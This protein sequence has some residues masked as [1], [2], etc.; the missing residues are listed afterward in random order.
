MTDKPALN[1]SDLANSLLGTSA[2]PWDVAQRDFDCD[3]WDAAEV[4][5]VLE[6]DEGMDQCGNCDEWNRLHDID[7]YGNC[8]T[9]QEIF[10]ES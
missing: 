8:L 10:E 2:D 6:D 5:I 4:S 9:C 3:G 1:I 7:S